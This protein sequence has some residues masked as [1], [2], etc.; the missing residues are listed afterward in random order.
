MIIYILL[1]LVLLF[2]IYQQVMYFKNE[3]FLSREPTY[4]KSNGKI[5]VKK[6]NTYKLVYN[7]KD[8]YIW[9]P[10]NINEY[11]PIGQYATK[12]KNPPKK[13]AILV[14]SESNNNDRPKNYQLVGTNKDNMNVW[15]IIP[16]DGYEAMGHIISK[17]MPSIHKYRCIPKIF[18]V[19]DN[20]KNILAKEITKELNFFIWEGYESDLFLC[21]SLKND[22]TPIDKLYKFKSSCLKIE[23]NLD[24]K[25]TTNFKKIATLKGIN[26][27]KP[28]ALK[29]YC[30]IGFIAYPVNKDPNNIVSV[31][32]I[33]KKHC[34][35]LMNYGKKIHSFIYNEKSYSIW[36]P[37][38]F[39]G[40][41]V[42]S[43][44][45]VEGVEEPEVDNIIYSVCLDYLENSEY[46]RKMIWNNLPNKNIKSIWVDESEYFHFNNS[47]DKKYNYDIKIDTSLINYDLDEFD[48]PKT[49]IL[50]YKI[51][52]NN[53]E[54][55]DE[56]KKKEL[57]KKSLARRLDINKSRL[58]NITFDI[59]NKKIFLNLRSRKK[60]TNEIPTIEVV[61]IM[62]NILEK[63]TIKI[64]N[65]RKTN[66]IF[67]ITEMDIR[68]T[69]NNKI[70]ID[71]SKYLSSI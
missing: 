10:E 60:N 53:T 28:I 24:I 63:Q 6:T 46:D 66:Y 2:S 30:A 4:G 16:R 52:Q 64:Y 27:W 26:F 36:E 65:S 70:K 50:K 14:K 5:L 41:G 59:Y 13:L 37:I 44:V 17:K 61:D 45:L 21:S 69:S 35:P 68:Y 67:E 25:N 33:H 3:N 40:Y 29:N 20:L 42:L 51:N 38:P 9:E 22:N 49:L 34:K 55:C 48:E 15:K 23:T 11:M 47:M 43:H 7:N 32:T 57:L 8:Y 56:N 1:V 58:E 31:S 39:N 54:N 18:L 19:E 71:N 62:E 12:T